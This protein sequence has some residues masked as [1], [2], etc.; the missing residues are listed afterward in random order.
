MSLLAWR[1]S[2]ACNV[3]EVEEVAA[4][5][6]SMKYEYSMEVAEGETTWV[7][8]IVVD[9]NANFAITNPY[10]VGN[11]FPDVEFGDWF[12]DAVTALQA[13]GIINGMPDGTFAPNE[14]VTRAQFATMI[15]RAMDGASANAGTE[16]SFTDVNADFWAAEAIYAC[17]AEGIIT[18]YPDGSFKPNANITRAE[19]AVMIYRAIG[20][21]QMFD[22]LFTDVKPSSWYYNAVTILGGLGIVNGMGDGLFV[23]EATATRAQAAQIIYNAGP[24]AE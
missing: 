12:Y 17:A 15:Y 11:T 1:L 7:A 3:E 21:D 23:P 22:N 6:N 14:T 24:V 9:E 8:F 16:V 20:F 10:W 4:D 13:E 19:M 2:P 18:G 5:T